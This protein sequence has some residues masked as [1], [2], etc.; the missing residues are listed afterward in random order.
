[1]QAKPH[2]SV[3]EKANTVETINLLEQAARTTSKATSGVKADMK[4]VDS[5]QVCT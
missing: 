3:D 2:P 4:G 1:M 5:A